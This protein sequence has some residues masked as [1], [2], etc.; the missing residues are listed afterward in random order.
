[1]L[2]P[3]GEILSLCCNDDTVTRQRA[4]SGQTSLKAA[5]VSCSQLFFFLS[6]P[7]HD[8]KTTLHHLQSTT[9]SP[10]QTSPTVN[11]TDSGRKDLSDSEYIAATLDI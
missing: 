6:S 3:G 11:M 7:I 4:R 8:L 5:F 9:T 2:H 1:M 10:N